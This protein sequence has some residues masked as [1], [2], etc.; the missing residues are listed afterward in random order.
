VSSCGHVLISSIDLASIIIYGPDDLHLRTVRLRSTMTDIK[1][2]IE[3]PS[4]GNFLLVGSWN[5]RGNILCE[6]SSAGECIRSYDDNFGIFSISPE[7]LATDGQGNIYVADWTSCGVL[8]HDITL[9][10]RRVIKTNDR[11]YHDNGPWRVCYSQDTQQLFVRLDNLRVD[12]YSV[13]SSA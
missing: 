11:I 2:V 9:D 5:D 7:H 8:V 1:H 6:V 13:R 4:S 10:L 3:S 12:I